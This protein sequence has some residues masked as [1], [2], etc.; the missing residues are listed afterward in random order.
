MQTVCCIILHCRTLLAQD[1]TVRQHPACSRLPPHRLLSDPQEVAP[2]EQP[3]PGAPPLLADLLGSDM[4]DIGLPWE[5][6]P[7]WKAAAVHTHT[8]RTASAIN[9]SQTPPHSN[10]LSAAYQPQRQHR[11]PG[12]C[13]AAGTFGAID[14]VVHGS[15]AAAPSMVEPGSDAQRELDSSAFVHW[16]VAE[17]E[18]RL[19]FTE[20]LV[21]ST[22]PWG[23]AGS[24]RAALLKEYDKVCLGLLAAT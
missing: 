9:H 23:L 10:S 2:P 18:S 24:Q 11:Q 21:S 15:D 12:S 13:I 8:V 4:A 5:L 16:G 1:L 17:Q 20:L 22:Q 19:Q 3:G 6:G 14:A 7:W